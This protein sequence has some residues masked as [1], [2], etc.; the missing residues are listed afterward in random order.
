MPRVLSAGDAADRRPTMSSTQS[1]PAPV[2]DVARSPHARLAPVPI[3]AVTLEGGLWGARYRTD[4]QASLL[5]QWER[6]EATGRLDN[7]RRV[8]GKSD[9][10]FQGRVFND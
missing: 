1:R 2:V 8:A 3:S 10:P 4:L 6:L 9:A 7:F 5:Q